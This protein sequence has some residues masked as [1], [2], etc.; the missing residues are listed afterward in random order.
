MKN[1]PSAAA[2]LAAGIG[3][4]VLGIVSALAE[5][6]AAWSAVL[7]WSKPV[8]ALS[9]KTI[10]G[11]AAWLVSWL[12]FGLLWKDREVSL[13]PVLILSVVLLAAGLLLTFPPVFELIA[14]G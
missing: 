11:I 8:G 6:I 9:G 12:I 1:G 13:R 4:A 14:G 3:L 10:L 7:V 5:A 2:I